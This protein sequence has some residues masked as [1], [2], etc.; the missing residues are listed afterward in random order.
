MQLPTDYDD[1][2]I[3]DNLNEDLNL[4]QTL[5]E[6]DMDPRLFSA[7]VLYRRLGVDF[8]INKYKFKA[9]DAVMFP[10]YEEMAVNLLSPLQSMELIRTLNTPQTFDLNIPLNTIDEN[11]GG[12]NRDIL[13]FEVCD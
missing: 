3:E 6:D 12:E 1:L 5:E 10:L 9:N 8:I 11:N 2:L 7:D 13:E 4:E